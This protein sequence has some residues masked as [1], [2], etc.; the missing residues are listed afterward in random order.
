V[1]ALAEQAGQLD[2]VGEMS[3]PGHV[4]TRGVT[5][6]IERRLSRVPADSREMLEVAAVIGRQ[7]DLKLIHK[8]VDPNFDLERWLAI[9]LNVAVLDIQDGVWQFTHDKLRDGVLAGIPVEKRRGL[10]QLV[11]EALVDVYLNSP[12]HFASAAFHWAM[13]G[14]AEQEARFIALTG[15]NALASGAYE[16]AAAALERALELL[17]QSPHYDDKERAKLERQAAE[18]Y[19]GLGDLDH[20]RQ[21]YQRGLADAHAAGYQW[22]EAEALNALGYLAY[23]QGNVSGAGER[24]RTALQIAASIRAWQLAL[25]SV[26]GI[27]TLLADRG[28]RERAAELAIMVGEHPSTTGSPQTRDRAMR[29]LDTLKGDL[30][31]DLM[32]A[33]QERG[34]TLHLSEVARALIGN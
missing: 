15:K 1:R 31:V 13:A 28:E 4:S 29:L 12:D 30:P 24:F 19:Q 3:L 16:Q 20:A 34:K 7:L 2:R 26:I 10:H 25:A 22:G 8:L 23:M 17:S 11:G 6:I 5:Q 32:A 18:A 9:C 14:D 21:L 33:A 27:A